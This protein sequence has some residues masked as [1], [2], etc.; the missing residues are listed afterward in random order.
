MKITLKQLSNFLLING[1]AGIATGVV[2]LF[3]L[4][5]SSEL[6]LYI[7]ITV[8]GAY[9]FLEGLMSVKAAVEFHWYYQGFIGLSS[10]FLLVVLV[11][12][13]I[14]TVKIIIYSLGAWAVVT[15]FLRVINSLSLQRYVSSGWF[16]SMWIGFV[17]LLFGFL[18]L[19]FPLF[20][21]TILKPLLTF[22]FLFLGAILF[23]W[24]VKLRELGV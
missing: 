6:S 12:S 20:G 24:G 15:G 10:L 9:L 7:L 2:Y 1:A 3:F 8:L 4:L 23:F 11:L 16:L 21:V 5:Y 14:L 19:F 17:S 18:L 22:Y 13:S